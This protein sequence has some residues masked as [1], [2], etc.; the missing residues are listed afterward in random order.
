MTPA[1]LPRGR[2]R[3]SREEVVGSQRERLQRALAETM[4]VK[5]YARTSVADVLRAAR[6]SRETF[7]EQFS[8][9]EDC[10][11]SVFE[12]AYS[13]LVSAAAVAGSEAS[14]T[15]IDWFGRVLE[16]YLEA[17]AEEP[18]LARVFLIEVNAAGPEALRRR[19]ELQQQ[20]VD[21][22]ALR[23]GDPSQRFAIEALLA[24]ISALVTARLA[25]GDVAGLRALHTPLVELARKVW[26]A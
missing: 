10:F 21:A 23:F 22:L 14:G 1:T 24:A 20:L 17:L 26:T 5:G 8:G 2:H 15:P 13:Q 4:A 16:A 25:T 11:M 3:L 18:A 12:E 9:K 7:Y 19:A 6:V